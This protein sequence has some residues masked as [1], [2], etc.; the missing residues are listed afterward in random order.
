MSTEAPKKRLTKV[1]ALIEQSPYPMNADAIKAIVEAWANESIPYVYNQ[2]KLKA[3]LLEVVSLIAED[4]SVQMR[5]Y[6][7]GKKLC[8]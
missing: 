7:D 1:A 6:R 8:R 5:L 2:E 3:E 4:A